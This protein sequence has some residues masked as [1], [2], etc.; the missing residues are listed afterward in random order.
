MNSLALIVVTWIF[1]GAEFGL[2]DALRLGSTPIAPSFVFVLLSFI[3]ITAKPHLVLWSALAMGLVTD[4]CSAVE[5]NNFAPPATIV[6]PHALGYLL[7]AQ[8]IVTMRA[9]LM[10][11]NPPTLGFTAAVGYAV[12]QTV[13]V[14][15]FTLRYWLGQPFDWHPTTEMLQ[16]LASAG[17]TGVIGFAL[18]FVLLPLAPILGIQSPQQRQFSRR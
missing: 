12:A 14:A 11:A 4:L 7:A 16:R 6:G 10:R 2:R 15:I 13:V 8:L 9:L 17:Y 18:S 1:F 5:L 3:A